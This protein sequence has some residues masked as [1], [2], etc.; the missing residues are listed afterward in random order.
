MR[1]TL[2]ME[3]SLAFKQQG[4]SLAVRRPKLGRPALG[5]GSILA[6][7][8]MC[9]PAFAQGT[10]TQA[11]ASGGDAS[12]YP[13]CVGRTITPAESEAAHTIYLAGRVQY[14]DSN[15]DAAIAQ[16]REAYRRD[17]NRHEL[18]VILSRAYEANHDRQEAI[19]ALQTYLDRVPANG[20]DVPGLQSRL[21]NIKAALAAE[22]KKQA[23]SN[24]AEPPP[25]DDREPRHHTPYPWIL[26]GVGAAAMVTG[27]VLFAVR[28]AFPDGACERST[29]KCAP[30]SDFEKNR[31]DAEAHTNLG[32]WGT[33][34]LIGGGLAAV[35][36][37]VWY[38]LEPT[39]PAPEKT[40]KP[41]ARTVKPRILPSF[42]PGFAGAAFGGTF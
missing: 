25:R 40:D 36:G 19:N 32:W 10:A 41:A 7:A 38:L 21:A 20:P 22:K 35:G 24:A 39:D 23:A 31:D 15:W 9:P 2:T 8:C 28:P 29:N 33:G 16:F 26:V 11:T 18:L 13:S 42:G 30:G 27:G 37:V 4:R 5:L 17:C 3:P 6:V 1:S 14:D 12:S 34:L